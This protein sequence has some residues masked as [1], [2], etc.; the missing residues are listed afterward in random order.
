LAP[1]C[2]YGYFGDD[3]SSSSRDCPESKRWDSANSVTP[4]LPISARL[5][6][7]VPVYRHCRRSS[8]P[9][10]GRTHQDTLCRSLCFHCGHKARTSLNS[11]RNTRPV[12]SSFRRLG[13]RCGCEQ[14]PGTASG[15]V[16]GGAA[17][18]TSGT[19]SVGSS[20]E[21]PS[22]AD[23]VARSVAKSSARS[24][25]CA[26]LV[27][28]RVWASHRFQLGGG[29]NSTWRFTGRVVHARVN[30]ERT[31]RQCRHR[32]AAAVAS[33]CTSTQQPAAPFSY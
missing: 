13:R 19:P 32:A 18:E 27:N 31:H 7:E 10:Q 26:R 8:V 22:R 3:G 30:D 28:R 33:W 24:G 6:S 2:R 16:A 17:T 21:K 11:I 5:A 1:I 23:S 12:T 29:L 9:T 20:I 25:I 4:S 14:G 15:S